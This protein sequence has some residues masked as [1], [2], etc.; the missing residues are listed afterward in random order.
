MKWST[1]EKT[2]Q[3][4]T[5]T[6]LVCHVRT[7]TPFR[8]SP[9]PLLLPPPQPVL[10][11]PYALAHLTYMLAFESIRV[12]TLLV[13]R[14]SAQVWPV[15]IP[16][17][18]GHLLGATSPSPVPPWRPPFA[19]LRSQLA[20]RNR[21]KLERSTSSSA[22]AKTPWPRH[23]ARTLSVIEHGVYLRTALCFLLRSTFIPLEASDNKYPDTRSRCE[24]AAFCSA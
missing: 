15:E 23:T 21:R 24:N 7:C 20:A 11:A 1:N 5:C 19:T 18:R 17:K 10:P 14:V 8:L 12:S 4:V 22:T 3:Q 6:Q 9:H 16:A 13:S 2:R